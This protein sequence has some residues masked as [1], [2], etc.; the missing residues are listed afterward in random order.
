MDSQRFRKQT[1][2][3][4]TATVFN[5]V[6]EKSVKHAEAEIKTTVPIA[7]QRYPQYAAIMEDGR[8]VTD[9]KSHCAANIAPSKYGNSIRAWF[10]NNAD[11]LIQVSRKRQADRAGAQYSKAP[12][13]PSARQLQQCTAYECAFLKNTQLETIGLERVEGVPP[14]F[15]T[16]SDTRHF[17]P[18]SSSY[19]TSEYE[20]GR[21]TTRGQVFRPLGTAP[22][23]PSYPYNHN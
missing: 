19:F 21:N 5:L 17:M 3:S 11:A 12:T 6:A 8:L 13:V 20:G 22:V 15:G 2:P 9:Y 1:Y 16:F 4:Y 23:F 7:D 18:K 10:Q 14:L